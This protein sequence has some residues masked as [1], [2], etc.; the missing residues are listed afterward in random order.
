MKQSPIAGDHPFLK[1]PEHYPWVAS[2]RL[3]GP[4]ARAKHCSPKPAGE[5]ASPSL[6]QRLVFEM[7]VCVRDLFVKPSGAPSIV[8]IANRRH[9]AAAAGI[10]M[11]ARRA[12]TLNHLAKSTALR[13]IRHPVAPQSPALR[14][15]VL[16]RAAPGPDAAI[17]KIHPPILR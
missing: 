10:S 15:G 11:G 2:Q 5:A 9:R 17:L 4:P 3:C 12:T 14:A 7:V 8:F 16:T 1:T 6:N 13:P